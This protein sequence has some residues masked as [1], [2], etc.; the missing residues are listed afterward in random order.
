MFDSLAAAPAAVPPPPSSLLVPSRLILDIET[1]STCDLK[2]CGIAV[3]AAHPSTSITHVG[4]KIGD[5]PVA[6]WRPAKTPMPM[7]LHAALTDP[8]VVLVAHNAGFEYTLLNGTPGR[9]IGMPDLSDRSRWSCTA[10]R[11]AQLCLPRDLG[12]LATALNLKCQKDSVGHKLMLR[13]SKPKKDG[14]WHEDEAT[15]ERVAQY[16]LRDVESEAELDALLPP[17]RVFERKVWEATES[18]NDRGILVDQ[19]LLLDQLAPLVGATLEQVNARVSELTGT[20]PKISNHGALLKWLNHRGCETDS[21]DK[22]AILDLLDR[23]DLDDTTREVLELRRDAGGSSISKIPAIARHCSADGRLRGALIYGGASATARWSS[24]G[25]QLQNLPRHDDRF[26]VPALLRDLAL[27]PSPEEI[28]FL[29]GPPLKAVA[30][31]LRPVFVAA[32]GCRLVCGDFSQIEARGLAWFA[33]EEKKLAAFR[34][35][36]A[37][38]GPDIYCVTASG[39]FGRTITKRDPERQPGKILELAGG[40]GGGVKAIRKTARKSG[41]KWS[42]E[43]CAEYRDR[44]RAANPNI[45]RFWAELE[46][47]AFQCVA[48]RQ[49]QTA[50]GRVHFAMRCKNLTM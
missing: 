37:G 6:V 33:G 43:K 47:A 49:D 10:A 28:E 48:T 17:L 26:N 38:T 42:N 20:V 13:V 14:T 18:T 44:W 39:M 31:L 12:K 29:Y 21:T 41:L 46:S 35:L 3:Y 30:E 15:V 34:A 16:C 40:Y 24:H 1:R 4:Y 36:D 19:A 50:A 5:G 9:A 23:D 32:P 45:V 11:A 22:Y 25:A 7:E 2:R 8:H 27:S